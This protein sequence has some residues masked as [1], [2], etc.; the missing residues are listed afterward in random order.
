MKADNTKNTMARKFSGRSI[1]LMAGIWLAMQPVFAQA[2][3]WTVNTASY[4]YNMNIIAFLHVDDRLLIDEQDKVAAF[5]AGE[6]RGVADPIFI[7]SADRYLAYLTVFG[8]AENEQVE[9]KV[10][11]SSNDR[12]VDINRRVDF[13]IDG[14]LG[15]VFQAFSL[16]NPA[17]NSEA[18][19][20]NFSF[21]LVEPVSTEIGDGQV[22][23]VVEKDQSL[24][25]LTPEFVASKGARVYIE[26]ALRES[27]TAAADFAE[28]VLYSVLSE[29]ESV[30]K[31]W[32]VIV[33]QTQGNETG[34]FNSN[35]ITPNSDGH[36][37]YWVVTD[38]FKYRN[39]AFRIFD[40]NGRIVFESTGYNNDWGGYYKGVRL[41]RGKY[42]FMI[43]DPDTGTIVKG[44]ILVVY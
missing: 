16:A 6:V 23:I 39:A 33:R 20:E 44:D 13:K 24:S 3:S 27:G 17:L 35:V 18:E 37:D 8:N 11:D 31:T 12:I 34:F 30:L 9:F 7:A 40:A 42:Y 1:L 5:V 32:K 2:P 25:D 19:I 26:R 43:K 36:N 15:N 41:S 21:S 22:E 14:Q 38:A 4:Q 29:D 10:Y 28:P